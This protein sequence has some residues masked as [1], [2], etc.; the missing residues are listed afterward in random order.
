MEDLA[1]PYVFLH[2]KDLTVFD[3]L[4]LS[5][6]KSKIDADCCFWESNNDISKALNINPAA[7][8]NVISKL[9]KLGYLEESHE[10]GKRILTYT[11]DAPHKLS[12]SGYI[13]IMKDDTHSYLKIGF[14]TNPE[15]RESTLQGEKP[16]ITLLAKYKGTMQQEQ[17]C[18]RI[19][20]KYRKRGE[21]FD[22]TQELAERTIKQVIGI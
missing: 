17:T 5:Y 1:I 4:I 8:P 18:H 21:W 22:I 10:N 2:N 7:L 13:Y 20:A 9:Y 6:I 3:S 16:T 15:Y 11:Y 14:S 12:K 19:L